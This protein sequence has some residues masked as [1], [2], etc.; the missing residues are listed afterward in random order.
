MGCHCIYCGKILSRPARLRSH[1]HSY[2]PYNLPIEKQR[3]LHSEPYQQQYPSKKEF[4]SKIK[5]LHPD[6]STDS[7][8]NI[9]ENNIADVWSSSYIDPLESTL[10]GIKPHNSYLTQPTTQQPL[11]DPLA[12][13]I[14]SLDQTMQA[15]LQT[16]SGG[17]EFTKAQLYSQA[18]QRYLRQADQYREKPLGKVTLTEPVEDDK[19]TQDISQIKDIL[20]RTLPTTL[21]GGGTA[22]ADTMVNLPGVSW[23]DKL[24]LIVGGKTVPNSNIVDLLTDLARNKRTSKPPQ[25]MD[26]LLGVLKDRNIP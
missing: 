9:S 17:D 2:H 24:Q 7:M 13:S 16:P 11:P 19:P 4:D 3:S 23:D 25:G 14:T 15:I 22:L 6:L 1:I 18:L 10:E 21:I 12:R 20:R 26:E 5:P 8:P